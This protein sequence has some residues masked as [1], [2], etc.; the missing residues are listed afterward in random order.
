MG[1]SSTASGGA[2]V[3]YLTSKLACA[4]QCK[5]TDHF[6]GSILGHT[7][8]TCIGINGVYTL[9]NS[10]TGYRSGLC[11]MFFPAGTV[12]RAQ[13]GELTMIGCLIG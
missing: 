7:G 1:L 5:L 11:N 3:T 12:V 13:G 9:I 10:A 4:Q 2:S 6:Q 8:S